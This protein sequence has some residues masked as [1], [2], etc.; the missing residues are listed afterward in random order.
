M[1]LAFRKLS[2]EDKL[3]EIGRCEAILERN[4]LK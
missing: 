1:L 3:I 4:N 2:D